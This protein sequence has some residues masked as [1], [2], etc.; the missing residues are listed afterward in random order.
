MTTATTTRRRR[1]FVLCLLGAANGIDDD[2]V[3]PRDVVDAVGRMRAIVDA[4]EACTSTVGFD[5]DR[6]DEDDGWGRCGINNADGAPAGVM[7]AA[8]GWGC[9]PVG[10]FERVPGWL[11]SSSAESSSMGDALRD[12]AF[13]AERGGDASDAAGTASA[14]AS[15]AIGL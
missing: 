12:A 11:A 1:R 15:G 14:A 7:F 2:A 13:E 8:R 9:G 6:G 4:V 10:C 3:S 5:D